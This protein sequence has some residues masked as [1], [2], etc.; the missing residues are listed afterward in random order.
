MKNKRFSYGFSIALCSLMLATSCSKDEIVYYEVPKEPATENDGM[1]PE[2]HP[3]LQSD[4]SMPGMQA[5]QSDT[6]LTWK[7]PEGWVNGKPSSVRL[8]SYAVEGM[9]N[10][11]PDISVTRFPGDVGGLFS[12]VNRWRGQLG[13]ERLADPSELGSIS[14]LET[15]HFRFKIVELTNE[16]SPV[17]STKVAVLELDGFS[18]FFKITGLQEAVDAERERFETFIRSVERGDRTS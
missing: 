3:P 10:D 7:T 1:L 11:S 8:G 6:T 14:T 18:W 2:G 15:K 12:N 5:S 17:S 9:G 13:M 16:D 4:I